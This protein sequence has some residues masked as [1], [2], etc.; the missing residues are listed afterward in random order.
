[1]NVSARTTYFTR[2]FSWTRFTGSGFVV[3]VK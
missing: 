2:F 3:L 1:M